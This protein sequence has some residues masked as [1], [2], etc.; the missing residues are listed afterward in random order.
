MEELAQEEVRL[1][2]REL[3]QIEVHLPSSDANLPTY[4][5]VSLGHAAGGGDTTG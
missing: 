5:L 4:T 2:Q 1:C 3:E